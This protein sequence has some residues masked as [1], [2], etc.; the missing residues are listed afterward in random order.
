M[1]AENGDFYVGG[2]TGDGTAPP[3]RQKPD[4]DGSF[5]S[6]AWQEQYIKSLTQI[7][8]PT[9]EEFKAQEKA[10]EGALAAAA[11]TTEAETKKFRLQLEA[12]RE[13]RLAGGVNRLGVKKGKVGKKDKKKKDK[14]G[15]KKKSKKNKDKDGKKSSKKASKKSS[16]R[17]SGSSSGSSGSGSSSEEEEDPTEKFRLSG[18][19]NKD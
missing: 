3:P 16:R 1:Q 15:K 17:S 10:R 2:G 7:N 12:D 4:D 5:H 13:R 9:Y 19:F 6:P 18:F 11:E 8:R 14:K